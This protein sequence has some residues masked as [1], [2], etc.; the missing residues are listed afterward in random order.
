[1]KVKG[2]AARNIGLAA[3][4]FLVLAIF[5]LAHGTA[6]AEVPAGQTFKP[7]QGYQLM[8]EKVPLNKDYQSLIDYHILSGGS[9]F[10]GSFNG[11]IQCWGYA[12]KTKS[13]FGGGAKRRSI[14]KKSTRKNVYKTLKNVKPGTHVRFGYSKSGN[15]VHSIAVYKVTKTKIYFSDANMDYNNGINHYIYDLRGGSYFYYPYMLWMI[16]PTGNYK[17]NSVK[18]EAVSSDKENK[19]ELVWAPVK[20]AKKYTVYRSYKKNG[21]YKKLK[22]VKKARYVDKT[23]KYGTVYYKVKAGGKTGTLKFV[24]KCAS[25]IVK[26]GYTKQG[27]LKLSWNKIKGAKKYAV[28]KYKSNGKLKKIKTVSGTSYLFKAKTADNT[29]FLVRSVSSNSKANSK[30]TYV[31]GSRVAPQAKIDS[32]TQKSFDYYNEVYVKAGVLYDCS[33]A[34]SLYL[35]LYRSESPNGPFEEVA[36]TTAFDSAKTKKKF[37]YKTSLYTLT[38]DWALPGKT[39]YYKVVANFGGWYVNTGMDSKVISVT[40]PAQQQEED[41]YDYY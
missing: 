20:G 3:A 2:K 9:R 17:S 30:G 27:Y 4:L 21:G 13:V 19:T 31:S 11:G 33:F 24:H 40:T 23:A 12:E 28:Y 35:Y 38:D 32:F 15:G 5:A 7:T 34:D 22:T 25:P 10:K 29:E 39:Y 37:N 26:T 41:S 8:G 6:S 18:I 36:M 14:K 1:M 16:E